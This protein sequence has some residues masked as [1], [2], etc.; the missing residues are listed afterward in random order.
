MMIL[1]LK[2]DEDSKSFTLVNHVFD[3]INHILVKL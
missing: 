3:K 2:Y 1:N